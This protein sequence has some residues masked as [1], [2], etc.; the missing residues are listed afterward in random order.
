MKKEYKIIAFDLDG[1][2]SQHKS[3]MYPKNK[4][5]L[6]KLSKKYKLLM[7]G[8]GE[9]LR[10]YNQMEQYPIEILGNYGMQHSI[11]EDGKIKIVKSDSYTVDKDWFEK[12]ITELR[13]KTGF[14]S[15]VGGNVEF[16]ES[17]MVTFPLIGTKAKIEDKVAFDPDRKKRSPIYDLVASKF[18]GFHTYIGGSS[19]FD[20]VKD[21]YGKYM[22]LHNFCLEHGYKDEDVLYFG[23]DF[24]RGGNDED[25]KLNGIDVIEVNDYTKTSELGSFLL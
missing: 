21:C 4:E 19:S 15:Y 2:L 9:C 8:A 7:V 25:V 16:H 22:A 17:G 11:I 10:I 18:V 3:P 5:F 24:N 6:D 20:I 23:D 14:T 12:T 1:T 13:K